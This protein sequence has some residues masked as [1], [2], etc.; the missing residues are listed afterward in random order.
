MGNYTTFRLKG[1][2]KE[3]SYSIKKGKVYVDGILRNTSYRPGAKSIFDDENEKS[4][5]K[6]QTVTFYQNNHL[7]DPAIEIIVNNNNGVLL[8]FIKTHHRYGIDFEI[9]DK[10]KQAKAQSERYDNIYMALDKVNYSD[11]NDIKA[12]AIAV[13]GMNYFTETV[14]VCR[15]VLKRRATEKPEEILNAYN[16]PQFENRFLVSLLFCRGIIRNNATNTAVLWGDTGNTILTVVKGENSIERM[17]DYISL[18]NE[19]SQ[20]LLQAFGEKLDKQVKVAKSAD[21][22]LA[23]ENAKLKKELEDA[24]K[25]LAQAAKP[26]TEPAK[27]PAKSDNDQPEEQAKDLPLEEAAA[28]YKEMTGNDVPTKF[29]ADAAWINKQLRKGNA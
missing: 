21:K 1:N 6:P 4:K 13:L 25:A 14:D 16:H 3:G 27:E 12:A 2:K 8:D 23:D 9:F 20:I 5:L 10:N 17:T 18:N 28:K 26:A 24:K 15:S 29:S 22:A 11:D 7:N 19:D